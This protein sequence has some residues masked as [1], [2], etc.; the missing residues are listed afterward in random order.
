MD[1]RETLHYSRL[2][3]SLRTLDMNTW[4]ILL[5]SVYPSS[6]YYSTTLILGTI[7]LHSL[8]LFLLPGYLLL[9]YLLLLLSYSPSLHYCLLS[10]LPPVK[11]S[12]LAS[13]QCYLILLSSNESPVLQDRQLTCHSVDDFPPGPDVLPSLSSLSITSH[14][15]VV[16]HYYYINPT[17]PGNTSESILLRE[18]H[19]NLLEPSL[20]QLLVTTIPPPATWSTSIGSSPLQISNHRDCSKSNIRQGQLTLYCSLETAFA[21]QHPEATHQNYLLHHRPLREPTVQSRSKNLHDSKF[22]VD[23]LQCLIMLILQGTHPE[24]PVQ[25]GSLHLDCLSKHTRHEISSILP[26]LNSAAA[27]YCDKPKPDAPEKTPLG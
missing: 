24:P 14:L 21:Y 16:L 15:V 9:P 1:G 6:R 8:R 4:I 5:F 19:A 13:I 23:P 17:T 25:I 3:L 20:G 10:T 18:L 27:P 22:G 7:T 26:P 12:P 2:S 11:S